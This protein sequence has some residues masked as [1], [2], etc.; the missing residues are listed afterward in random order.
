MVYTSY[1]RN[2]AKKFIYSPTNSILK[3]PRLHRRETLEIRNY[4]SPCNGNF[5]AYF[6]HESVQQGNTDENKSET[7]IPKPW[8]FTF[9]WFL[10]L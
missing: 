7:N 9:H 5:G 1:L 10:A 6:S 4:A 3:N 2:T 8:E